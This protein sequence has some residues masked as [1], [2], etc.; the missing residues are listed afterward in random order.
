MIVGLSGY[1]RSGKDSVAEILVNDYGFTRLAFADAIRD[2]LYDMDVIVACSPTGRIAGL[3]DLVG[4]DKAKETNEV[5]RLLQNLGVA[6]R[7]RVNE[8]IWVQ[9]VLRKMKPESDYVITDV[10]FKNEADAIQAFEG[11]MW[12]VTRPF[13]FPVND[14]ISEI[15]LD[16]Y[17]DFDFHLHNDKGLKE[18]KETVEFLIQE[19][20]HGLQG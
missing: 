16:D 9:A 18:L 13:V 11:H 3:V 5:R 4:W 19:M 14:H 6:A 10:R 15:D 1:A 7:T 8:N 17:N 20:R 2:M 12:R